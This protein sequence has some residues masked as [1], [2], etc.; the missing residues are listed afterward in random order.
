M[1]PEPPP[2][3]PKKSLTAIVLLAF[4]P[5]AAALSFATTHIHKTQQMP[6]FILGAVVSL[7]CGITASV[8]LFKRGTTGAIV[9]GI[10]IGLVNL[11]ISAGFGCAAMLSDINVH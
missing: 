4:L 8:M 9:F 6:S 7:I 5:S 10:L 2:L 3:P 1:N 11:V